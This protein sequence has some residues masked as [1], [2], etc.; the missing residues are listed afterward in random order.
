MSNFEVALIGVGVFALAA[1]VLAIGT[2]R[3]HEWKRKHAH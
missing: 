1:Y 2:S 3:W